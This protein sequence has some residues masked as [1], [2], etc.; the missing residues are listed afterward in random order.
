MWQ[1][2]EMCQ[3]C[4]LPRHYA[5]SYCHLLVCWGIVVGLAG[6]PV[7]DRG[8]I[9][10]MIHTREGGKGC[11]LTSTLYLYIGYNI[12]SLNDALRDWNH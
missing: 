9:V 4:L 7:D 6:V 10:Y 5:K 8:Y 11:T 2:V 3:L 1:K 12:S